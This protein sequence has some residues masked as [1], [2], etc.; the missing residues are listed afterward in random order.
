MED[1]VGKKIAKF[2]NLREELISS[3]KYD[4]SEILKLGRGYAFT[5]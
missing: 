4:A 1:I 3:K 2:P 5:A